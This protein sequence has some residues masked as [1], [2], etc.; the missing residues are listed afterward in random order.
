MDNDDAS[1]L[2]E[3]TQV[4]SI[5]DNAV[6]G[7]EI[8]VSFKL[9]SLQHAARESGDIALLQTIE[10]EGNIFSIF[11]D[12][13]KFEHSQHAIPT[14]NSARNLTYIRQRASKTSN[15]IATARYM[16]TIA[17]ITK[18]AA[19]A[20]AAVETYSETIDYF[21][22]ISE[23]SDS[24][25]FH[26]LHGLFPLA[27]QLARRYGIS[28]INSR[29]ISFVETGQLRF[30]LIKLDLIEL[31]LHD[32]KSFKTAD[33]AV[34]RDVCFYLI[35]S[36]V[37]SDLGVL[38]RCA[39]VGLQVAER[40]RENRQTWL[41]KHA[42]AYDVAMGHQSH[43]IGQERVGT[44]LMR[45][46]Q[47]LGKESERAELANRLREARR[48]LDTFVISG[49]PDN[50]SEQVEAHRIDARDIVRNS[51]PRV[52][53][54]HLAHSEDMLPSVTAIRS[55][56]QEMQSKGIG[57]FR[58]I[59]STIESRDDRIV[60]YG[61]DIGGIGD[62]I[63]EQYGIWWTFVA[64]APFG[65]YMNELI[66]AGDLRFEH[67]V[68]FFSRSWLTTPEDRPIARDS[69]IADDLVELIMPSIRLYVDYHA[70]VGSD[71]VLVPIVDSLVVRFEECLR[72]LARRLSIPDTVTKPDD[73]GNLVTHLAGY[74]L[75]D[76]QRVGE[77]CGEDLIAF[78]KYTLTNPP[79]G[80]RHQVA[81]GITHKT[82]YTRSRAD[83]ILFLYLRFA[84]LD[85]PGT[86]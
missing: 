61:N 79:E 55:H 18:H 60:G 62:D 2:V 81:H 36:F 6:P 82:D 1:P 57:I 70:S 12:I 67:F 29:I 33:F 23:A 21:I 49:Q 3:F 13:D 65:I 75:L 41:T 84:G 40:L 56:A 74:Q 37:G 39:A 46:Y 19:D 8:R 16:H 44:H 31:M 64:V 25:A 72:K 24:Q 52:L 30:A 11:Q 7:E 66:P 50:W 48:T 42:E 32:R 58:V 76:H 86:A 43:P 68:D 71:D 35:D 27:H 9:G 85:L 63:R 73:D 47:L 26:A 34:V 54:N 20:T 77:V 51:G 14:L 15:K 45:I 80:F 53:L 38:D 59:A 69:K 78:A 10:C 83:S 22:G 28:D 5:V 4:S 17:A